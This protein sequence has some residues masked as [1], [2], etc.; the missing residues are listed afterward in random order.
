MTDNQVKIPEEVK[1]GTAELIK[2]SA[3]L[4]ITSPEEAMIAGQKL[5]M[6]ATL[7]KIIED[8]RTEI[9]KPI[10]ASLKSINAMFKTLAAP[11][12]LVDDQIRAKVL[13][14]GESQEQKDFVSVHLRSRKIVTVTD[15]NLLPREYLIPNIL[16]ITG[17]IKMGKTIPGVTV[18]EKRSVSL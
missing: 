18:E 10:N 7:K 6:V 17:D 5:A 12:D 9:T 16:R 4:T 3:S 14:F 8:K 1:V 2:Y 13:E 15:E 11:L